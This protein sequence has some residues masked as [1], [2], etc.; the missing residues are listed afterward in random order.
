MDNWPPNAVT[1]LIPF[2]VRNRSGTFVPV[3]DFA[4]SI[5]GATA[6][7]SPGASSNR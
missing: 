5:R 2:V 6:I 4:N 7:A 3:D 1:N